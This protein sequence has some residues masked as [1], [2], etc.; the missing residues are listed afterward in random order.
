M[1]PA[2]V[3]VRHSFFVCFLLRLVTGAESF[4]FI[5]TSDFRCLLA[6]GSGL[7]QTSIQPTNKTCIHRNVSVRK[8][9][10]RSR[11][12]HI[13]KTEGT[14]L[15]TNKIRKHVFQYQLNIQACFQITAKHTGTSSNTS[16]IL[17][18]CSNTYVNS[19]WS[20]NVF[21]VSILLT[22]TYQ[23]GLYTNSKHK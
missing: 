12:N 2:P 23:Y 3:T 5:Y 21:F 8:Q 10:R 16:K 15:N 6:S 1:N 22:Y 19:L 14:S 18:Q 13:I 9:I 20:E 4:P 11:R 7:L 17:I